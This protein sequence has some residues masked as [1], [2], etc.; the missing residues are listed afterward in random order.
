MP[1][2]LVSVALLLC[3][4]TVAFVS[5]VPVAAKGSPRAVETGGVR[6]GSDP[7]RPGRLRR[8]RRERYEHRETVEQRRTEK[9]LLCSSLWLCSSVVIPLPSS[10]PF[11]SRRR[12]HHE[13]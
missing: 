3:G 6:V 10:P 9:C 4:Y 5:S 8:L 1:S 2:L 11:L 12:A 13:R 7:D